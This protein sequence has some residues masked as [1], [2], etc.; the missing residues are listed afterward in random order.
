MILAIASIIVFIF[1]FFFGFAKSKS[2]IWFVAYT[3]PLLSPAN[4]P[5]IPSDLIYLNITRVSL[6]ILIGVHI[7]NAKRMNLS[8]LFQSSFIK[9]YL[10]FIFLLAA[11]SFIDL[12]KN[13][14]FTLIPE[15][16]VSMS[17]GFFLIQKESDF[18]K[19]LQILTWHGLIFCLII[20]LDFFEIINIQILVAKMIPN[21][22]MAYN[23]IDGIRAGIRR[24]S[25][26]DGNSINSAVRLVILFPISLLLI[27]FNN[28]LKNYIFPIF[29]ILSILILFSRAAYISLILALIFIIF[30]Q[31]N[32]IK[33]GLNKLVSLFKIL[34]IIAGSSI[35]LFFISP[36]IQNIILSLYVFSTDL[37]TLTNLNAR[38]V[39][40][41]LVYEMVLGNSYFGVFRSPFFVYEELLGGHDLPSPLIYSISGG[42][43]LLLLFLNWI[44]IMP[45]Y[46]LRKF[47][48]RNES[49]DFKII[50]VY[51]SASFIGG[52]IPVFSNWIDT[53]NSLM[54]I[55][56]R[57]TY[58]Y[59]MIRSKTTQFTH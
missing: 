17:L 58:K 33:K 56:F 7:K 36:F 26:F 12:G 43:P 54:I 55:I 52:I 31:I 6:A 1:S 9:S 51:I 23:E 59:I 2:A 24:V 22:N 46:F 45:F 38:T 32:I 15:V 25:G 48:F 40:M 53:Q 42:I 18:K 11:V 13:T 34:I 37:S 3:Y 39:M 28:K 27:K 8:K 20:Y 5:I 14:F 4:F 16:Y 44:R 41:P 19:L 29:L 35:I 50:L 47:Y 49:R 21:F 57:A 10:L 30:N